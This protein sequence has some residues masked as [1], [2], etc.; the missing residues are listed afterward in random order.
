[1]NYQQLLQEAYNH[2]GRKCDL[3]IAVARYGRNTYAEYFSRQDDAL[4]WLADHARQGATTLPLRFFA[5]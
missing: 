2:L 1:M 5:A 4:I 3:Y